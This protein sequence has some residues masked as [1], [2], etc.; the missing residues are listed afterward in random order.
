[1]KLRITIEAEK[2]SDVFAWLGAAAA[3]IES[4]AVEILRPGVT[5]PLQLGDRA[6]G[7]VLL[8]RASP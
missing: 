2:L 3:T 6:R 4:N 5:Q 1:M 8:E 7:T